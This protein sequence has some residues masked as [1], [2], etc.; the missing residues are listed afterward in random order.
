MK[1]A[2]RATMAALPQENANGPVNQP[3]LRP[4]APNRGA[5]QFNSIGLTAVKEACSDGAVKILFRS[6]DVQFFHLLIPTYV[7]SIHY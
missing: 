4:S 3:A 1:T 2:H 5:F 7:E 6:L